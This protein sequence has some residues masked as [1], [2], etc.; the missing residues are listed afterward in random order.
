MYG[1]TETTIWSSYAPLF[2]STKVITIGRPFPNTQYYVLDERQA[3]VPIGVPG[4][5]LIGGTQL[6]RGYLNR[7]DLTLEKFICNPFSDDVNDRLYK[8][9]DLCRWLPDGNLEYLGRIDQQVKIRGYRIELRE[10]E[11]ALGSHPHVGEAI[12]LCREDKPLPKQLVAYVLPA[13]NEL[14]PSADECRQYLRRAL[15]EYMIPSLF[16]TLDKLPMTP[17]G[18]IDRRQLP[19]PARHRN[20]KSSYVPPLTWVETQLCETW[21]ET[22]RVERVGVHD[23][24]FELGGNSL[25]I[26]AVIV[27]L[28]NRGLHLTPQQFFGHVDIAQLSVVLDQERKCI[29]ANQ[30]DGNSALPSQLIRVEASE[31]CSDSLFF[32]P[33]AMGNIFYLRFLASR[34]E[35]TC[36]LS[37]L[38]QPG[39]DGKSKPLYSIPEL[40][41]YFVRE[42]K[43]VQPNGPYLLGGHSFGG[44]VALEIA[45]LLLRGGN[46]IDRLIIVDQVAPELQFNLRSLTGPDAILDVSEH[47]VEVYR[48][49]TRLERAELIGLS[50]DEGKDLLR[51]FAVSNS[52]PI[53]SELLVALVDVYLANM[54]MA[55]TYLPASQV[56]VPIALFCS[57]ESYVQSKTLHF[58]SSW[59]WRKYSPHD[60]RVCQI[61]GNHFSLLE[62]PNV[63]V[64]ANTIKE[65]LHKG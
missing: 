23:N 39:L 45:R 53:D 34:L 58:E 63:I 31:D 17:N 4:E 49:S 56:T 28:K 64:L 65:L 27:D 15:P 18:K 29:E 41:E 51:E 5:L 26:I 36:N 30:S 60:L 61:P 59:G 14:A 32:V 42:I 44:L 9:G 38:V 35:G 50:A 25:Q 19:A 47:F 16:I 40:A 1:P 13:T 20:L 46:E 3:L 33:G 48:L 8:T 57:E 6:A 22:L 2:S 37:P 10:I 24:F 12:V 43:N 7:P 21:Q 11:L 52:I 55:N 54:S 62:D